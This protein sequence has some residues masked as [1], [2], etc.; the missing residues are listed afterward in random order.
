VPEPVILRAAPGAT[1]G[2]A[3][4]IGFTP[5]DALVFGADGRRLETVA[6]AVQ[7]A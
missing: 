1:P 2:D 7:H 3:P 4:Q 6:L 5:S